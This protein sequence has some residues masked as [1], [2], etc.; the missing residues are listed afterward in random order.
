MFERRVQKFVS[1]K[2]FVGRGELGRVTLEMKTLIAAAA[3]QITFGHP[4]IYFEHFYRI[5]IY[6]DNYYSTITQKYHQGEVHTRGFI[7]LSWKNLV[8]GYLDDTDGR[9]LALHEMAHALKVVNMIQSEEYNFIHP[10]IYHEYLRYARIEMQKIIDGEP[11]F[12]RD[13]AGTN[14]MEFFAIAVE[15]FFERSAEFKGHHPRMYELLC[16]LLNQD[17]LYFKLHAA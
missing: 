12:F 5:L 3:V 1:M 8:Q 13:Y 6:P 7:V 17:P 14:D 2:E 11:S 9:N 16:D 4:G 10:D 15:N